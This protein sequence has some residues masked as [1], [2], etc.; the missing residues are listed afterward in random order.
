VTTRDGVLHVL[1]PDLAAEVRAIPVSGEPGPIAVDA[2][3]GK[4]FVLDTGIHPIRIR[5]TPRHGSVAIIESSRL[6]VTA[7]IAVPGY[8]SSIA[9]N[10]ATGRVY[11]SGMGGPGDSGFVQVIDGDSARE[12]LLIGT[13][14]GGSL[15]SFDADNV[16]YLANP[17]APG[18]GVFGKLTFIDGR[19]N[20]TATFVDT[21]INPQVLG[22]DPTR[23]HLYQADLDG[24]FIV[25][26]SRVEY[27]NPST[28]SD[29]LLVMP[30]RPMAIVADGLRHKVFVGHAAGT[31]TVIADDWP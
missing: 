12:L 18:L 15:V 19:R 31:I 25:A 22:T 4:I 30:I 10:A 3:V 23:R 28:W 16:L 6:A 14:P 2:H 21:I 1:E 20:T 7:T 27:G 29:S 17:G 8:P 5:E 11:V 26:K 24:R 13:T 9:V